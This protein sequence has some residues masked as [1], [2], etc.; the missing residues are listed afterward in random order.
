MMNVAKSILDND[1][2]KE[3]EENLLSIKEILNLIPGTK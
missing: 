1:R 3:A 2:S